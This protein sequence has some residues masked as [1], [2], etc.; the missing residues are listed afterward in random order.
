MVQGEQMPSVPPTNAET[1]LALAAAVAVVV[2]FLARRFRESAV[3]TPVDPWPAEIDL[4]VRN[5]HS[6]PLCTNCLYPQTGSPWFCPHCAFPTGHFVPLMPYLQLFV[7]GEVFRR[8]VIGPPEKGF[9]R[10]AFLVVLSSGQY[11]LFAPLYWF[12]MWRRACGKPICAERRV[13][14]TAED[15]A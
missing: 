13:E 9:G 12:W 11:S 15:T 14:L 2:Y 3:K 10:K 7:M 8:G 6:V 4:A 5:A 1:T